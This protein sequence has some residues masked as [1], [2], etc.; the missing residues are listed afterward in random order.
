MPCVRP[1]ETQPEE[2]ALQLSSG[3]NSQLEKDRR[4][5]RAQSCLLLDSY[6]T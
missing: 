1:E 4:E 3:A 5:L 2:S 6:R